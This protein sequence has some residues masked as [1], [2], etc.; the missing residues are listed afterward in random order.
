MDGSG[1]RKRNIGGE[2]NQTK[3][4]TKPTLQDARA[5]PDS[6]VE[7]AKGGPAQRDTPNFGTTFDF[8]L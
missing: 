8:V 3:P 4:T 7:P 2:K 6:G 1:E 5:K